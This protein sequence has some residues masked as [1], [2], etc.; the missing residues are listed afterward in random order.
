M[1]KSKYSLG[2]IAFLQS[3]GLI[4]YCGLVALLIAKGNEIFGKV[5]NYL[6][7]LLFL[8]LFSSSALICGLITLGYP[9]ILFW[10]KKKPMEA[11]RLVI[12]TTA[13]SIS[14]TILILTLLL[15]V[16]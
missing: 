12:Y 10:Q 16:C 4:G 15:L 14:F 11:L 6:G 13:W 7:P 1:R 5:P 8:T 9:F 3:L 2:F